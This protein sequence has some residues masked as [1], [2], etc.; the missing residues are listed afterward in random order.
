MN[1]RKAINQYQIAGQLE[2][3]FGS[4]TA[5]YVLL[6]LQAQGSAYASQIAD[7][8]DIRVTAVQQ[9]LKKFEVEGI[10]VS[11]TV[12]RTRVFEFNPRSV[13][14][15]NLKRFLSS[16]LEFIS[17]N[18]SGIP[19]EVSKRYFFQRQRPRR[20]GKST[21]LVPEELKK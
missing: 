3:L 9:Q 12:G 13:T 18:K 17:S 8:F 11:R 1:E 21:Q 6:Y 19:Q 16:E 4:R 15:Q 14:V 5:A 20:T 10:L 2:T 7:T